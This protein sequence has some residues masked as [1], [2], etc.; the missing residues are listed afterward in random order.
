MWVLRVLLCYHL[1]LRL[2]LRGHC[3]FPPAALYHLLSA[4]AC[5]LCVSKSSATPGPPKRA[6]AMEAL[7]RSTERTS[8]APAPA[9]TLCGSHRSICKGFEAA[10]SC[11]RC[12][13]FELQRSGAMLQH[14]KLHG[15]KAGIWLRLES[16]QARMAPCQNLDCTVLLSASFLETHGRLA[17]SCSSVP[18][19]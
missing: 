3:C 12:G 17:A 6:H 10:T 1:Q 9:L 7:S 13:W 11:H 18:M 2:G 5:P 4:I 14:F 8:S 16:D 19:C 15:A